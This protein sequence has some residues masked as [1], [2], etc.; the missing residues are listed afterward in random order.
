MEEAFTSEHW[1]VRIFKVKKRP[2]LEPVL[3]SK[4]V[5]KNKNSKKNDVVEIPAVDE[6]R[7]VGCFASESS[8]AGNIYIYICIRSIYIYIYIHIHMYMYIHT[9]VYTYEH[10]YVYI[11]NMW[12]AL[13]QRALLQVNT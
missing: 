11:Y 7:Y 8:F 13:L 3:N 1:I 12:A 10:T 6:S 9:Y 5:K 2:N 4:K